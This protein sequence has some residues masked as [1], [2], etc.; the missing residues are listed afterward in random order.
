MFFDIL[1]NDDNTMEEDE[2]FILIIHIDSLPNGISIGSDITTIVTI[3]RN[4]GELMI[5]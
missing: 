3:R 1:I 5:L 4:D 2:E